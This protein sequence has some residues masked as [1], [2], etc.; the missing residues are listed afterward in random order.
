M[1]NTIHRKLRVMRGKPAYP[2]IFSPDIEEEIPNPYDY[3]TTDTGI[4]L[5]PANDVVG[6]F[7][8]ARLLSRGTDERGRRRFLVRQ[9]VPGHS[10]RTGDLF[11][12]EMESGRYGVYEVVATD[13]DRHGAYSI[14]ARDIGYLDPD[15]NIGFDS[16]EFM[17]K[18]LSA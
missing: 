17:Q 11:A 7:G 15:T 3:P 18:A 8:G 14:Y 13:D 6:K 5:V 12:Y 2:Q 1:I 10:F 9:C 4:P 16:A